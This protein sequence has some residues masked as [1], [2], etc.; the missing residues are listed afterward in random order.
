MKRILCTFSLALMFGLISFAQNI[1]V[2]GNVIS[3]S[4][5]F[6]LPGV[7]ILVKDNMGAVSDFD[8]NF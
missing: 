5:G 3:A 7:N 2:T 4:D 8:G 1:E 6:P